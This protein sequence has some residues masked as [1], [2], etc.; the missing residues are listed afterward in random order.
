MIKTKQPT[1]TQIIKMEF[2]INKII[3]WLIIGFLFTELCVKGIK[4][5]EVVEY[6]NS[7]IF[8]ELV[9]RPERYIN[10]AFKYNLEYL[11]I[12]NNCVKYIN[13]TMI[14]GI[15]ITKNTIETIKE[16]RH[17][18]QTV[19]GML[20][21][22]M[23]I[24]DVK[25]F[26]DQKIINNSKHYDK[27]AITSKDIESYKELEQ[28]YTGVIEIITN[29]QQYLRILCKPKKTKLTINNYVVRNDI[30]N[31]NSNGNSNSNSNGNANNLE[32]LEHME[33]LEY[34]NYL[35]QNIKPDL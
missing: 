9:K 25:L 11:G 19:E 17:M 7:K 3:G 2:N 33:I 5:N 10:F 31:S 18:M 20:L 34:I 29:Y 14:L 8:M 35:E 22:F 27:L 1:Q 26:L 23:E 30:I 4:S 13:E 15:P 21:G 12:K 24:L 6:E 32:E 28:T 16:I